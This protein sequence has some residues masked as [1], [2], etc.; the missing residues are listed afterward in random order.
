MESLAE[1]AEVLVSDSLNLEICFVYLFCAGLAGEDR[2]DSEVG[3]GVLAAADLGE[4]VLYS[5][6]TY[7]EPF[8]FAEPA[9][10]LGF[11]DAGGEVVADLGQAGF[12]GG[13]RRAR[14]A[15]WAWM[16]SSG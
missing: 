4:L 14:W 12:L 5:G 10:S 9:F 16:A 11:V 8:H 7:L 15:W 3:C 13:V 2:R 1:I 6:E